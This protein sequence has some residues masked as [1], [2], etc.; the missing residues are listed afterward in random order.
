MELSISFRKVNR[1]VVSSP[2]WCSPSVNEQHSFRWLFFPLFAFPCSR[3]NSQKA[4]S[5]WRAARN[6][7]WCLQ[8]VVKFLEKWFVIIGRSHDKFLSAKRWRHCS[9]CF[10]FAASFKT[11]K[12]IHFIIFLTN[13]GHRPHSS[14]LLVEIIFF[15]M[16]IS[17]F[18]VFM[19]VSCIDRGSFLTT[20]HFL[21]RLLET[22]SLLWAKI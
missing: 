1:L 19:S 16:P 9:R 6:T 5:V 7:R 2:C 20:C 15:T 13:S 11:F 12:L 21:E 22:F 10:S 4:F 17:V 8:N 14:R 18:F 3:K